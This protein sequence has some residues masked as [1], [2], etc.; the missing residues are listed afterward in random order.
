MPARPPAASGQPPRPGRRR[1][2]GNLFELD[3]PLWA[4][5]HTRVAGVDEAGR[6]PLAGP[7][8][9]AAVIFEPRVRLRGLN[10]SK[11]L[12]EAR[13]DDLERRIRSR[14]L[15]VGVGIAAPHE[16]DAINIL[17]A[18]FLAA[19][20]AI[21]ALAIP[22]D[23]LI[24]DALKLGGPLPCHP[25]VKADARSHAVAAASVVAKVNRDRLMVQY[26]A[27]FPGYG[28]A[29]HK[30][31]PCPS[32]LEAL[33]RLG[34]TTIHRLTFGP[35]AALLPVFGEPTLRRSRTADRLLACMA[36]GTIP[37]EWATHEAHLRATLPP[38]EIALIEA[39]LTRLSPA[40][41]PDPPT[42]DVAATE[43]RWW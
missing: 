26:D 24:T 30:G 4:A 19:R 10:D 25:H 16:I 12:T 39:A 18:T 37:L 27:D 8:V 42:G 3:S 20:R 41:E 23:A 35:V 38:R 13:R 33:Q 7:V 11:Q 32:H 6:G 5:G 40:P 1:A 34:P 22:P 31:Y 29:A 21:A 14:A 15:A 43:P 17:Q 2:S 9:A 28:L 36:G